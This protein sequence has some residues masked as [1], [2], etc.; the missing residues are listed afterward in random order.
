[1]TLRQLENLKRGDWLAWD[2]GDGS[3]FVAKFGGFE[4]Q[5]QGR[6]V[7]VLYSDM[8]PRP[9]AMLPKS[10]GLEIRESWTATS[11][12]QALRRAKASEIRFGDRPIQS[13]T[14]IGEVPA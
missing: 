5:P 13:H 14:A 6:P 11:D 7:V 4:I 3:T 12:I 2:L 10:G 8:R 1:M 9:R